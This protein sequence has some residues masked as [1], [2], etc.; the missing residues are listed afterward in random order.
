MNQNLV[1]RQ[2]I[3]FRECLGLRAPRSDD[4]AGILVIQISTYGKL[5][6]SSLNESVEK[7]RGCFGQNPTQAKVSVYLSNVYHRLLG[8]EL[9][10]IKQIG[11]YRW[12]R[13]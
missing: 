5:F 7:I 13:K 10:L 1:H 3:W 4:Q 11:L 6:F 2:M 12:R 9:T 8:V